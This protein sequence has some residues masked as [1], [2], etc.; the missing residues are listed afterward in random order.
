[1]KVYKKDFKNA[2]LLCLEM[3]KSNI[4]TEKA[5]NNEMRYNCMT[6]VVRNEI[7][8]RHIKIAIEEFFKT[9]V[10]NVRV[11]NTKGRIRSFQGRKFSTNGHKKVMVRV[12]DIE[13]IREVLSG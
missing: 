6:F 11:L 1:M 7:T 8:K 12:E 13:K 4:L 10:I 2:D 5:V 9:A 3:F